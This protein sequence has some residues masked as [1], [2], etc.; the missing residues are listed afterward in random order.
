MVNFSTIGY[1]RSEKQGMEIFSL[2]KLSSKVMFP[3]LI[4]LGFSDT[5][6]LVPKKESFCKGCIDLEVQIAI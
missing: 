4:T 2:N 5:K 3:V 6:I 1:H